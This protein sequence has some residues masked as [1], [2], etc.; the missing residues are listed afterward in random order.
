MAVPGEAGILDASWT[1]PTTNTDGS[2]LTDLAS[3]RVYYGPADSPCP[4]PTFL[5]VA[6]PTPSPAP[7]QPVAFRLRGLSTGFLYYVSVTAVN[8]NRQESD[9]STPV[10]SAGAHFSFSV[11]PA[12]TVDFGSV[13]LGATLPKSTVPAVWAS[14]P[15]QIKT[16]SSRT[17]ALG[18]SLGVRPSRPHSASCLGVRLTWPWGR[19]R[20]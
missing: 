3:Y 2:P 8:T 15:S 11:I 17:R 10:A 19:V 20:P 16:S 1:A 7:D 4:G 9:C 12:G 5:E 14:A 13:G 6:S 18:Q